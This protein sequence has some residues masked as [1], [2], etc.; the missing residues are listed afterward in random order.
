MFPSD[1]S[2]P[3][4]RM[5]E[6]LPF[7]VEIISRRELQD[8][9]KLRAATYGKHLPDLAASL[10]E[11]EPADYSRGCEVFVARSKLDNSLLGTL[12]THANVFN[13]LPL[14]A[15]IEL[16][17]SFRGTRMVETTRLCV[18]GGLGASVVRTALFK[19]MF[20]YCL[21][22]N[23]DWM[24]A[25]ARKP[26]D[27]IHDSLLWTDVSEPGATHPMAHAGGVPHRV[28]CLAPLN[29]E[30]LWRANQHPLCGFAFET[31]HPDID[32]SMAQDLNFDW[33]CPDSGAKVI[34]LPERRL[35]PRPSAHNQSRAM[36]SMAM[37]A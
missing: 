13:P 19:A 29:A 9:A 23:V 10:S 14:Q 24:L 31:H 7:R 15:S 34:Y 17:E 21:D 11:P 28:L 20:Q 4:V 35:M 37:M 27:R 6:L 33:E 36:E 32:I 12:R 30:P 3:V 18:K 8:V 2:N 1:R 16:P 5:E 25:A 22:Q 26:V